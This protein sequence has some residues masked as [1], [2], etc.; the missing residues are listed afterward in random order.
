MSLQRLCMARA[1]QPKPDRTRKRRPDLDFL[2]ELEAKGREW[3]SPA[4]M[5]RVRGIEETSLRQERTKGGGPHYAKDSGGIL[6]HLPSYVDRLR[7]R[8][9]TST[10]DVVAAT[11]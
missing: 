3:I 4:E 1:T 10:S 6:Y 9:V 2:A 8:L 7:G 11:G 5:A